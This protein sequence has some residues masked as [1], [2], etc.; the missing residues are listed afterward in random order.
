[1]PRSNLK[2]WKKGESGNPAGCNKTVF[3]AITFAR[4]KS[5]EALRVALTL[6]MDE[7]VR[8]QD[9]L[10]ACE[11]ILERGLGKAPQLNLNVDATDTPAA[12]KTVN[13]LARQVLLT[14]QKGEDVIDA[15]V[16][17]KEEAKLLG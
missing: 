8:A 3:E 1:M 17:G 9:R 12:K 14:L 13:I 15:E 10:K 2:P 5:K 4:P 16:V 11:I 7:T 6:M